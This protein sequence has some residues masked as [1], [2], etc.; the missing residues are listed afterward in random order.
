MPKGN[1]YSSRFWQKNERPDAVT[2]FTLPIQGLVMTITDPGAAN[3]FG[4]VVL[5][6]LPNGD[7]LLL[8]AVAYLRLTKLTAGL[9]DT[10]AGNF[11]IGTDPTVDATLTGND[12]TIMQSQAFTTAVAGVSAYTHYTPSSAGSLTTVINNRD[13]TLELNLNVFI[14]DASIT[15]G[16]TMKVDGVLHLAYVHLGDD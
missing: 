2:K 11:S 6:D 8:G 15:T 4:S 1:Y 10:F 12:I 16:A 7:L 13:G 9:V 5:G 3:A 14:L